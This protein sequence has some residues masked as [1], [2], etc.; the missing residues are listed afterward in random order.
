MHITSNGVF[1]QATIG[2]IVVRVKRS[3][4]KPAGF[5]NECARQ[6]TRIITLATLAALWL[7]ASVA[8][9]TPQRFRT[10]ARLV[11]LN[12]TVTNRQG[13]LITNLDR[14]AFRVYEDGREQSISV[15]R[16]DD[17][18]VSLG[19]I[20]DNSRSMA[21][22]RQEVEAAAL[23]FVRASNP[24]DEVFVLSFADTTRIDVP[25]TSD[26]GV[27]EARVARVNSIGGTAVRDAILVGERYL[28]HYAKYD[29]RALVAITDGDDTASHLSITELRRALE[30]STASIFSVG[31]ADGTRSSRATAFDKDLEHL[32][33]RSGGVHRAARPS[34]VNGVML[35]IAHQIRSEYT[36]AYAPSNQ[37]LDGSYRTVRVKIRHP[38]GL[39]ARTRAGYWALAPT[40]GG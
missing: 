23:A 28:S 20:I 2:G 31:I 8:A 26:I 11:V 34:D 36:I 13:D 15:F 22:L 32:I 12:V 40:S 33:K 24:L 37:A 3:T 6:G 9:Q 5:L 35:E 38:G 7:M 29:R 19:L 4:P 14:G 21:P 1:E 16:R 17:V 27:L 25:F 39:T 10:E 30:K 18:P